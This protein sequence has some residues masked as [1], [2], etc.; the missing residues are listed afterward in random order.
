MM[1]Y[2]VRVPV[3]AIFHHTLNFSKYKTLVVIFKLISKKKYTIILKL[4]IIHYFTWLLLRI[5]LLV[6]WTPSVANC[7]HSWSLWNIVNRYD[8][9]QTNFHQK[10]YWSEDLGYINFINNMIRLE[11]GLEIGLEIRHGGLMNVCAIEDKTAVV[12]VASYRSVSRNPVRFKA[13]NFKSITQNVGQAIIICL[14]RPC[15]IE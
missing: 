11:I 6:W 9:F 15:T 14:A 7:H 13:L 4:E 10:S 5:H 8:A 2:Q 3:L 1:A 12:V